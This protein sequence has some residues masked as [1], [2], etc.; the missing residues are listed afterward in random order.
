MPK[1]V[2]A[3][4]SDEL[5]LEIEESDDIL[6]GME[7]IIEETKGEINQ[8]LERK[9]RAMAKSEEVRG[10]LLDIFQ[11]NELDKFVTKRRHS[12]SLKKGGEPAIQVTDPDKL[13]MK[14]RR[15]KVEPKKTDINNWFKLT[16]ELIDGCEVAYTKPSL[17][18]RRK[19]ASR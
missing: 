16:G 4:I 19:P 5:R 2:T 18:I 3:N 17:M 14:F 11:A 15:V 1:T 6:I 10:K 7:E 9:S 12:I 8:L 13:P